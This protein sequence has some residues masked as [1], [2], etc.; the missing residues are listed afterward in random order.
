MSTGSP[1]FLMDK[2]TSVPEQCSNDGRCKCLNVKGNELEMLTG[3][4]EA[5]GQCRQV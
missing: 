1:A 3:T 5:A 2:A 4:M